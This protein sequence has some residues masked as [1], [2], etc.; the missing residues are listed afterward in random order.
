MNLELSQISEVPQALEI[1]RAEVDR[2]ET[3]IR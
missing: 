1:L 3:A 2:A